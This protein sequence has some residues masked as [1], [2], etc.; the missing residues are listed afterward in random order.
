MPYSAN[1]SEDE[2][3]SSSD[4]H[5]D[6]DPKDVFDESVNSIQT[7]I[8]WLRRV[9]DS[10]CEFIEAERKHHEKKSRKDDDLTVPTEW[11]EA[12]V[13][14]RRWEWNRIKKRHF[15]WSPIDEHLFP[16]EVYPPDLKAWDL[17]DR[18][19][20][21]MLALYYSHARQLTFTKLGNFQQ[22]IG[23]LG[24]RASFLKLY[25]CLSK[26]DKDALPPLSIADLFRNSLTPEYANFARGIVDMETIL[27][28]PA[29][30]VLDNAL[31]ISLHSSA[32]QEWAKTQKRAHL[33]LVTGRIQSSQAGGRNGRKRQKRN[34]NG[35]GKAGTSNDR[36]QVDKDRLGVNFHR[37][38]S[39]SEKNKVVCEVCKKGGHT[40]ANCWLRSKNFGPKPPLN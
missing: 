33:D 40:K 1:S 20:K 4:R 24:H 16:G 6:K 35:S 19:K 26:E 17:Y 8:P 39:N 2:S 18:I 11:D 10:F 14:I 9:H 15:K 5:R 22:K 3:K 34:F 7:V 21:I 25:S 28:F 13:I 23:L 27:S 30:E 37:S 36:A 32:R 29:K 38:L 31:P 12:N